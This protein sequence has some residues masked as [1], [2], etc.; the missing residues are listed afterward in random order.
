MYG[1][2]IQN[3]FNLNYFLLKMLWFL[4]SG[5]KA[6]NIKYMVFV[7][8]SKKIL[9]M[10]DFNMRYYEEIEHTRDF[11]HQSLIGNI[12]GYIGMF[13][14]VAL[15]QAPDLF[16]FLSEKM[17]KWIGRINGVESSSSN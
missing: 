8:L 10:I 6:I 16:Q 17:K 5:K 7:L 12:G 4:T 13:I 3:Q 15:W 11:D 14:G 9:F 2:A 1:I